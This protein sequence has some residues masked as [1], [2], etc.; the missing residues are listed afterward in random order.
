MGSIR[1]RTLLVLAIVLAL[2]LLLTA[3]GGKGY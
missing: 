2:P 1:I 3:C